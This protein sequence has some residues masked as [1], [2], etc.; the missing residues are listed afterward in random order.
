MQEIVDIVNQA[1]TDNGSFGRVSDALIASAK[2]KHYPLHYAWERSGQFTDQMREVNLYDADKSARF[3]D[4]AKADN[5]TFADLE[6]LYRN[7]IK[8]AR[9][10]DSRIEPVDFND[11]DN[12]FGGTRVRIAVYEVMMDTTMDVRT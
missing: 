1:A 5:Y 2:D 7:I 12:D 10:I 8:R 9:E 4:V 3:A 11:F 6:A